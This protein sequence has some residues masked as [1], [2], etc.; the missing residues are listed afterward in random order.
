M[1]PSDSEP[2]MKWKP[3]LAASKASAKNSGRMRSMKNRCTGPSLR[4]EKL[5]AVSLRI[6]SGGR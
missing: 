2:P 1:E 5:R 6:L 4:H 3:S